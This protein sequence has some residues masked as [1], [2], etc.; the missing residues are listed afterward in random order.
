MTYGRIGTTWFLHIHQLQL[1]VTT[2]LSLTTT[3]TIAQLQGPPHHRGVQYVLSTHNGLATSCSRPFT[4]SCSSRPPNWQPSHSGQDPSLTS[5][6]SALVLSILSP[7]QTITQYQKLQHDPKLKDL[8]VPVMSKELFCLA[9]GKPGITKATNTIF[10]LSH[11]EIRHILKDQT[12]TYAHVV[13]NHRP[14]KEDPNRIRIT[15]SENLINYPFKLTMRTTNIIS[16]KLLWNSTIS[17]PRARFAG[18]DI[19]NTY[20]ETPLNCFEYMTIPI[21][22]FPTNSIDHYQLNNKVLKDYVYTE[23]RK[24]MYDLP[25]ASILANKLLKKRL[26]KHGYFEQP[27]TPGLFNHESRPIWLNLVAD[28]FG[29]KYIG[30]NTLQHLYDSL[31]NEAYNIVE[32]HTGDLYCGINL[33]WN[34]A[35]GYVNLSMPKHVMKQLTRYSHPVPLKP[36][37]C[38]FAPTPVTYGKYNQASNPTNDSPLLDDANKKCIQQVVGSFLYYA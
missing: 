31:R 32:D 27:H 12:V 1:H 5:K 18:A 10:F 33:K 14:Q 29:I 34:Y 26:A 17:M 21:S 36:Q 25:Q 15:V 23:I 28:D 24:G 6:K 13:I 30:K 38:P 4:M 11:D 20:L 3:I 8:W 37:N 22:L 9:Q 7:K 35:K 16:S 19:K 2:L